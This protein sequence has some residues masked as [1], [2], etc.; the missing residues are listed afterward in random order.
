MK[1]AQTLHTSFVVLL[2]AATVPVSTARRG[3]SVYQGVLDPTDFVAE[4]NGWL[5]P[6][7]E[8]SADHATNE[9]SASLSRASQH[10]EVSL[11]QHRTQSSRSGRSHFDDNTYC[12]EDED[13]IAMGCN[14]NCK[15][16]WG[17]QCY[18]KSTFDQASSQR[19]NIGVCETAMPVLA[20]LSFLLFTSVL[21]TFVALRT[22]LQW[23]SMDADTAFKPPLPEDF[24]AAAPPTAAARK[25]KH[26]VPGTS[27]ISESDTESDESGSDHAENPD[28]PPATE[29]S[30]SEETEVAAPDTATKDDPPAA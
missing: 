22:F 26:P 9:S 7:N 11:A 16:G 17:Q 2:F 25:S 20:L 8:S 10:P 5:H 21:A 23:Q 12:E 30:K 4:I 6:R 1:A 24:S 19:S 18:P 15:C 28:A 27:Q 14:I 13:G 3:L 29:A